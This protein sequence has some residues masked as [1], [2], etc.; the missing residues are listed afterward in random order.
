MCISLLLVSQESENPLPY[1]QKELEYDTAPNFPGGSKALN[2]FFND[3][4]RFPEK[5][6]RKGLQGDV[7]MKFEVTETGK[8]INITPI[9]GV[10]GAPEFVKESIRLLKSMP[11]WQPAVKKGKPIKATY[12]LSIPFRIEKQGS[13]KESKKKK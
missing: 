12:Y 8:L 5:A 1:S 9:N 4:I 10:P 6:I 11:D 7:M 2:T 13:P 3:S